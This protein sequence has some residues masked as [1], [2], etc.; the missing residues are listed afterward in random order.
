MATSWPSPKR[1]GVSCASSSSRP[2]RS[3]SLK[4]AAPTATR[5]SGSASA[6]ARPAARSSPSSTTRPGQGRGREHQGRWA[7]GRRPGGAGR[8]LQGDSR[9]AWH[10][11]PRLP[12]RLEEGLPA[13]LRPGVSASGQRRPVRGAQRGEQGREMGDFLATLRSHPGLR[14]AIVSPSGEGIS[15]SVK[16]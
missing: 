8:R 4:S 7:L 15:V 6:C 5:P 2:T 16:R 10:V 9:A 12:R 11:R 3:G 14:S 1:T 13:L